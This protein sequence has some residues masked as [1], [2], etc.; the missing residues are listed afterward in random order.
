LRSNLFG[1]GFRLVSGEDFRWIDGVDGKLGFGL[2]EMV[3]GEISIE[4]C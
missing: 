1:I 2:E 3:V 4:N